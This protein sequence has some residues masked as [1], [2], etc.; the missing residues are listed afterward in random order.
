[1]QSA[2]CKIRERGREWFVRY[3]DGGMGN[4]KSRGG[5]T[6]HF[7]RSD[8][9]GETGGIAKIRGGDGLYKNRTIKQH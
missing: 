6:E 1:M 7:V 2:T 9:N 5:G 3:N 8:Q 4:T